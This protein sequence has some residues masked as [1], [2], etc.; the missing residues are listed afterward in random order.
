MLRRGIVLGRGSLGLPFR[1]KLLVALQQAHKQSRLL[2]IRQLALH[3]RT[4]EPE[5]VHLPSSTKGV[6]HPKH[7]ICLLVRVRA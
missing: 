4:Q 1:F 7:G 2:I 5:S 3:L 6:E